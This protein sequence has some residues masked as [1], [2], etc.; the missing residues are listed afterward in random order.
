MAE[1]LLIR[2]ADL[3]IDEENPRILEPNEG[4]PKALQALAAELKGKL[5]VHAA[6]IAHYGLD[7]S[8]LLIVEEMQGAPQ[9]YRVLEGNRRVACLRVLENPELVVGAVPAGVLK[10]LRKLNK[11]Y[12]KNPIEFV[13]AVVMTRDEARHW[14]EL[15]HT[16]ENRGAGVVP[17]GADESTR[18]QTRVSGKRT[19]PHMQ[20]IE[21]LQRRGDLA[22]EVRKNLPTTTFRRL[23]DTPAVRSR[24][25]IEVNDGRL[26]LMATADRVAKALMHVIDD[27]VSG[28]VNVKHVYT[29]HQ[30]QKYAHE[31]PAS[32]AVTPTARPGHGV[33]V[34]DGASGAAKSKTQARHKV[35]D[36]LIPTD[37]VLSI[38]SGRI[39]DIE[40]ELRRMLSLDKHTNAVAVLFRVF[41][42]LSLDKYLD[43]Y[44]VHGV[45]VSKANLRTKIEKASL[46]LEAG[47]RLNK[48][49][50]RAIRAANSDTSSIFPGTLSMNAFV[51][52]ADMFP[53]AG[54]LRQHW[55]NL[56]PLMA[57]IWT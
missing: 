1:I 24:L 56:Q 45:D 49:Q 19:P 22:G 39:S 44:P 12:L 57:A 25:G 20:A 47:G 4:Q 50:G 2:P 52:S 27:L 35:R 28:R 7:P 53:S 40:H 5:Y 17:W 43:A 10:N 37:C 55:N 8:A 9:R 32:V 15:R 11:D 16:G 31:L 51:H 13:N 14:I 41:V 33:P 21:F 36:R 48:S 42:E 30:R 6:D 34:T 18:Y 23:I 3:I 26:A 54:D 46:A 29:L 38:P